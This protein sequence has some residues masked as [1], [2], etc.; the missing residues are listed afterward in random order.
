[1]HSHR[2]QNYRAVAILLLVGI[3]QVMGMQGSRF[4]H[5]K[6]QR[7]IKNREQL[8]NRPRAISFYPGFPISVKCKTKH[9]DEDRSCINLETVRSPH[10]WCLIRGSINNPKKEEYRPHEETIKLHINSIISFELD[11]VCANQ[12]VQNYYVMYGGKRYDF[13]YSGT[14][15]K[16]VKVKKGENQVT[17]KSGDKTLCHYTLEGIPKNS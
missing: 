12:L 11:S 4:S 9:N 13:S 3:T 15:Y 16:R 8:K 1:M 6:A 2:S 10:R 17:L 14:S 5:S 7:L